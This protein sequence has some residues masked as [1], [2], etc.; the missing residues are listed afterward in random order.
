M[1]TRNTSQRTQSH[2][3]TQLLM[4]KN[5]N[6]TQ[7]HLSIYD[8]VVHEK[9]LKSNRGSGEVEFSELQTVNSLHIIAGEWGRAHAWI[10]D[11]WW[12]LESWHEMCQCQLPKNIL[13]FS[14]PL[15]RGSR[16]MKRG[17]KN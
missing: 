8:V 6:F 1:F 16:G 17:Q 12:I 7:G 2:N 14:P 11:S 15:R 10:S 9:V 13:L 3:R 4:A 5:R